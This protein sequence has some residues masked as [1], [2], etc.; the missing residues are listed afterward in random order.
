MPNLPI[1]ARCVCL[2]A[3]FV[4][5]R[6]VFAQDTLELTPS[7]P[8][9]VP[10]SAPIGSRIDESEL[11]DDAKAAFKKRVADANSNSAEA[12]KLRSDAVKDLAA[13]ESISQAK[14]KLEKESTALA[15]E[16]PDI[17]LTGTLAELESRLSQVKVEQEAAKKILANAEK[18]M[19]SAAT[20]RAEIEKQLPALISTLAERKNQAGAAESANDGSLE[21][22]IIAKELAA[23]V[24]LLE[25]NIESLQ[26]K[27]QLLD[28]RT[29]AG[30]FQLARDVAAQKLERQDTRVETL[31]QEVERQR[32]LEA[33]D[34]VEEAEKQVNDLPDPLKGIGRRNKELAELRQELADDITNANELLNRRTSELEDLRGWLTQAK[35]RVDTVGLTDAVGAF[36][37]N[38]KLRMPNASAYRLSIRDRSS[39]INSANFKLMEMT[40]ERNV[41]VGVA[42]DQAIR[43]SRVSVPYSERRDLVQT[44]K[45]L[46]EEQREKFLDPAVRDQTKYFNTLVSLSTTEQEIIQTVD[47]ATEYINENVLWIRSSQ[48]LYLSPLP[49]H[50]ET[51][52][53]SRSSWT[54]VGP[55]LLQDI[56]SR[57]LPWVLFAAAVMTLIWFRMRLRQ[58]IREIGARASQNTFAH[59]MPTIRTLLLTIT[60]CL[61]V[62]LIFWFL[63][64]RL[65]ASAGTDQTML[66]LASGFTTLAGIY[67]PLELIRQT[68][69]PS[70]LGTAH[71]QWPKTAL[72][73]LR[74]NLRLLLYLAVPLATIAAFLGGGGVSYGHDVLERYFALAA[75]VISGVFVYRTAHPRTGASAA[76]LANNASGWLNRLAYIWYPAL[77]AVPAI[78]FILNVLGYHFTSQQLGWRFFWSVCLLFAL[79]VTV[80]LLVRW[81]L[82]HRRKLRLE[83]IK[84]QKEQRAETESDASATLMLQES[85]AELQEQMVQSRNL[86]RTMMIAVGLIGLWLV[87][88]DVI[89]ALQLFERWPLWN[90]TQT[91]NEI[92][93]NET[94]TAT[95]VSREVVDPV[96]IAEIAMA[97]LVVI[98]TLGAAKNIPGLLEFVLLRRLPIDRSIRYAITTLVSYVIVM[99]GLIVAGG[100]IGLHWNQIQWMATALTFGLAFGLQEVFANFVA[101]II[102]LFEQPV[103]VGDVVEIDGVTGIVTR[104]RI[105]ATTITN[106]DRKDYIVPNKEFITGKLLNWT[107]SDEIVRVT[108]TVGVAYGSDTELAKRLLQETVDEHPEVL[109]DPPTIICFDAFGDN[110]LNFTVRVFVKTYERRM[111]IAHDLHMEIDRKFR[112]AEI[113]IS[114]PQR[115]LHIRSYPEGMKRF[116]EATQALAKSES[117]SSESKANESQAKTKTSPKEKG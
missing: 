27:K 88:S 66:A 91:I 107:R 11:D 26:A 16:S 63:A 6:C 94:G 36:L 87:W 23:S 57:P 1:H 20:E 9:S 85:S 58:T 113:E 79:A 69:R 67:F 21:S 106:W 74:K 2:V 7:T 75:T 32:A 14:Q 28:A 89:P 50:S 111:H 3:L 64:R 78:L 70:G 103:R 49:S 29:T 108:V 46:I 82:I 83:E 5:S 25:S 17:D 104:I 61:P 62:P 72:E 112:E 98:V 97:I 33:A 93:T 4:F 10:S 45:G 56:K 37:R 109:D 115:D 41:S 80:S 24:A 31:N 13:A 22:E 84:A 76:F 116:F 44:G 73:K 18:D 117:Q 38:L 102:I 101:G 60:T 65:F 15:K 92:V 110:S 47:E 81:S 86:A 19:T 71:F 90:S 35:S 43:N 53:L 55:R 39:D 100:T 77:V 54:Q 51:W 8:P 30:Y 99:V 68:C 95:S 34:R 40:D 96:T 12:K 48:P 52:F 105:R 114:F 59:F 42:V